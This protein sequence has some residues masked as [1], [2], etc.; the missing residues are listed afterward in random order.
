[1][2]SLAAAA[3]VVIS[4]WISPASAAEQKQT[5]FGEKID[6]CRP[7]AEQAFDDLRKLRTERARKLF[8]TKNGMLAAE[9]Q[10]QMFLHSAQSYQPNAEALDEWLS[11]YPQIP[12]G[13]QRYLAR[14]ALYHARMML[15]RNGYSRHH[16]EP[17]RTKIQEAPHADVSPSTKIIACVLRAALA[18]NWYRNADF[19][20]ELRAVMNDRI[21]SQEL[22]DQAKE[23]FAQPPPAI[24]AKFDSVLRSTEELVK[25]IEGL[26]RTEKRNVDWRHHQLSWEPAFRAA[27]TEPDGRLKEHVGTA[28]KQVKLI[29][30]P[31]DTSA[32]LADAFNTLSNFYCSLP[33][34]SQEIFAGRVLRVVVPLQF[35]NLHLTADALLWKVFDTIDPTWLEYSEIEAH[36]LQSSPYYAQTYDLAAAV[37]IDLKGVEIEDLHNGGIPSND[38]DRR[39]LGD[40]YDEMGNY[41]ESR[42][43]YEIAK[44]IDERLVRTGILDANEYMDRDHNIRMGKYVSP[45]TADHPL[46]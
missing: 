34:S 28:V 27:I 26:A 35:S 29:K 38:N 9:L 16:T 46:N 21:L 3:V 2:S 12:S 1:M 30:I 32:K 42:K 4:M 33:A 44:E 39:G 40:L 14:Y 36:L 13:S 37:K 23:V 22:R 31:S 45:Y 8:G 15:D 24:D 20:A 18:N 10:D 25:P 17:D 7:T 19:D 5:L 11:V 41:E 43:Q 6:P